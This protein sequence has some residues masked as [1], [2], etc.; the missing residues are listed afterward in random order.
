MNFEVACFLV[1][2]VQQAQVGRKGGTNLDVLED[3][4][5]TVSLSLFR[6]DGSKSNSQLF[7]PLHNDVE[8]GYDQGII[9]G[10]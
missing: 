6:F 2:S 5:Y 8:L 9:V 3:N 1:V 7:D 4:I 10:E